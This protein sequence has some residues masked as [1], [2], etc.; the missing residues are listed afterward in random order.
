[1]RA[2]DACRQVSNR[3][4]S[5]GGTD[6]VIPVAQVSTGSCCPVASAFFVLRHTVVTAY[7]HSSSVASK[8]N[9]AASYLRDDGLEQ[10]VA[11][12]PSSSVRRLLTF[13]SCREAILED[14][15]GRGSR[16][17]T[18]HFRQEDNQVRSLPDCSSPV[19]SASSTRRS[20]AAEKFTI[21]HTRVQQGGEGVNE[22]TPPMCIDLPT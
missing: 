21:H 16:S 14:F 11:L 6:A 13:Q 3:S 9:A 8:E 4:R 20:S 12:L 19:I 7:V 1:M 15:W 10:W 22:V 2:R 18:T 17:S 5:G